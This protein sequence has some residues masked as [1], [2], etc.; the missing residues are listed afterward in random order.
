MQLDDV[1][2]FVAVADA[3]SVSRAAHEL[4]LTQPAVTRGVQ[5]LEG[6]LGAPL[7]D[8]R[9]RPFGL[10]DFGIRA[11]ERCRHLLASARAIDGLRHDPAIPSGDLRV[12]V[13]HALSQ[14]VLTTPVDHVQR[15]FPRV[16]LHLQAGWSR[17]L[18][19]RLKAGSLDACVVLWPAHESLPGSFPNE[20]L[21]RETIEFIA[22]RSTRGK[23]RTAPDLRDQAWILSPEG[24]AA[25]SGL[26]HALA[27]QQVPLQVAVETYNYDLQVAL[28]ARGR[29]LGAIPAQL[30]RQSRHRHRIRKLRIEGLEL[31]FGVWLAYRDVPGGLEPALGAFRDSVARA[32]TPRPARDTGFA[33]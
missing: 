12:G 31:S 3:G 13:A 20:R 1:R 15:H 5:R 2:A 29:G 24:C 8:R 28:V 19:G 17:E 11:L 6:A 32:V 18:L 27:L 7:L 22:S 23:A 4:H 16:T 9:V 33:R 14:A 10:T 21:G 25:R 30:L 26:R